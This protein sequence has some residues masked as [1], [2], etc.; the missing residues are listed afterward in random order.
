MTADR[1]GGLWR[2][3]AGAPLGMELLVTGG[4]YTEAILETPSLGKRWMYEPGTVVAIMG[5]LVPYQVTN[6][7]ATAQR[8]RSNMGPT[9]VV[10]GDEEDDNSYRNNEFHS[11]ESWHFNYEEA[12]RSWQDSPEE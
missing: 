12:R 10:E 3:R 7:Q 8:W 1:G 9:L 4:V 6:V 5:R 2:E 11:T